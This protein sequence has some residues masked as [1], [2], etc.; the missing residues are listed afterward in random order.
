MTTGEIA[1]LGLVI[2]AFGAFGVLIA[3]ASWDD[4][5]RQKRMGEHWYIK[6]K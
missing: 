5:R 6:P 3:F 1:Y 4:K 2:S